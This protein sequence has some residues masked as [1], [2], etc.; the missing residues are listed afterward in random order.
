MKII[1]TNNKMVQEYYKGKAHITYTGSPA[2]VFEEGLKI[3]SQGG[4]LIHDPT[5]GYGYYRTLM[6]TTEC[7]QI[8]PERD[9]GMLKKCVDKI[10]TRSA[11]NQEPI[12][13]SIFQKQDMNRVKLI[14]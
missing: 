11:K 1:V 3:V 13:A 12:F 4:R 6:F 8:P 2:E 7:Q 5:K 14:A 9:T 10:K